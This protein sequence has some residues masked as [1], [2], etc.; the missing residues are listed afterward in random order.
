MAMTVVV[1]R[2]VPDRFRGF[3][4][5]I[6]LEVSPGVYTSPNL[7][8]AVRERLWTVVTEWHQQLGRGSLLMIWRDAQQPGGQGIRSLGEPARTLVA[9]D[10]LW[11]S[12]LPSPSPS[13]EQ[14]LA[15]LPRPKH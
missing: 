10:G 7:P 5:S 12:R 13:P 9:H 6:M 2:D 11:L 15:R 1:T 3:L 4:A 8:S 14:V